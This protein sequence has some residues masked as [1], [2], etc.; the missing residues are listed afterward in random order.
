MLLIGERLYFSLYPIE[1]LPALLLI[2]NWAQSAV[3]LG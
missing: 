2:G 3:E 1:S